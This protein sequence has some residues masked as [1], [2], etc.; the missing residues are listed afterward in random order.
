MHVHFIQRMTIDHSAYA[1]F[2]FWI[3]CRGQKNIQCSLFVAIQIVDAVAF[4]PHFFQN[5]LPINDEPL[6]HLKIGFIL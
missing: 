5:E 6:L 1:V 2:F 4:T 3:K